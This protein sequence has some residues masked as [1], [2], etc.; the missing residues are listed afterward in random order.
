LSQATR[1]AHD[2]TPADVER[3]SGCAIVAM[4]TETLG[5]DPWRDPLCLVQICDPAG[6]VNVLKASDWRQ[7]AH[8]KAF[9]ATPVTKVFHNAMF[10]CSMLLTNVGVEVMQPY[11]TRIASKLARTYGR[12]HSLAGL[13]QELLG[14]DLPKELQASDWSQEPSE[15]QLAYAMRDVVNLLEV[16]RRLE[17]KMERRPP[18]RTGLRLPE[19]NARC[20]AMLPGLVQ[21]KVN[22]WSIDSEEVSTFWGR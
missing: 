3:L 1:V 11:C 9:L 16:K 22:G 19:L 18:L 13:V 4:D 20:Q 21:L 12:N 8:L 17:E 2:L 7:A 5:L 6:M 15:A 10:D 14:L